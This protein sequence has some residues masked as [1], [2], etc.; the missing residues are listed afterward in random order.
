MTPTAR[1][2]AAP[3]E[4]EEDGLV[5]ADGDVDW[6]LVAASGDPSAAVVDEV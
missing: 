4:R 3:A 2:A 1:P 6:V 5:V